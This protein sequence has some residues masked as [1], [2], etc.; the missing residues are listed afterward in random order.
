MSKHLKIRVRTFVFGIN[1]GQLLQA[2]GMCELLER[3]FPNASIKL[4][5]YH[6]HIIKEIISQI[7][8]LSLIKSATL[9]LNWIYYCKFSL[10]FT[11]RNI[12][13]FGADTI[14][15]YNHPVAPNDNFFFGEDIKEGLVVSICPSNAGS[16]YPFSDKTNYLLNKFK[17]VGVRDNH[18]AEFVKDLANKK[19]QVICDPAFF[20][21]R[22]SKKRKLIRPKRQQVSVYANSCKKIRD[23]LNKNMKLGHEIPKLNYLGYFPTFYTNLRKQ[24][25]GLYGIL[26]EIEK[27]KLLITD[28][29]HGVIMALMTKTPFILIRSPIVLARLNGPI[30]EC[31]DNSRICEL[32]QLAESLRDKKFYSDV[33]LKGSNLEKF[34]NFSETH[35]SKM[36]NKIIE[37]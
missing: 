26:D 22:N 32:D 1:H 5:L 25:L 28:T 2:K 37:G 21:D 33:D 24:F 23:Q 13:V 31:F 30:F 6:N 14:W 36:L 18:T 9:L 34:I 16:P 29:F 4:D 8:K 35:T 3:T 7:K 10:P 15:M 17:F 11:K 19:V 20:V 12:T 27:S